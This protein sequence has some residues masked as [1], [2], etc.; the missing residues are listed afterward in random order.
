MLFPHTPLL[1]TLPPG[2]RKGKAGNPSAPSKTNMQHGLR[3]RR[4]LKPCGAAKCG[5]RPDWVVLV[6]AWAF[7]WAGKLAYVC[8]LIL[9]GV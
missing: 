3:L 6:G 1:V 2:A 4:A 7:V 9:P 8:V 5:L